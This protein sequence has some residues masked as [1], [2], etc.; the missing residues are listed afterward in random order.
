MMLN[1]F[2]IIIFVEINLLESIAYQYNE[3]KLIHPFQT[4]KICKK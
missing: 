2:T 4:E 3:L 1:S